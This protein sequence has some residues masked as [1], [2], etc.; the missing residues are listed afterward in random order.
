MADATDVLFISSFYDGDI[1]DNDF[2]DG[3]SAGPAIA[4]GAAQ[5]AESVVLDGRV[6]DIPRYLSWVRHGHLA[7]WERY[8]SLTMTQLTGGLFESF[9]R[10]HGYTVR[11]ANMVTTTSL[12][13]LAKTVDPTFALFSTTFVRGLRPL[14]AGDPGPAGG[15]A[16]RRPRRR[17]TVPD[18]HGQGPGPDAAGRGVAALWC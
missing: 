14:P 9:L 4:P 13:A 7:E 8:E 15:L 2:A 17:R 3:H 11:V 10:R 18:L 12:V 1:W 5:L 16:G 6:M